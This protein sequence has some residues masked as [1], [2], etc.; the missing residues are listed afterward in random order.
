MSLYRSRNIS[1]PLIA[2]SAAIHNINNPIAGFAAIR[3]N[4]ATPCLVITTFL[5]TIANESAIVCSFYK[6]GIIPINQAALPFT[7]KKG[8]VIG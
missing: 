6:N 7:G 2:G 5:S 3:N 8:I 1:H 4:P